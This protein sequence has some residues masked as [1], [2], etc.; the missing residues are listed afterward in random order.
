[1]PREA[2]AGMTDN[3]LGTIYRYRCGVPEAVNLNP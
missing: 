3:D 1:M 2:F